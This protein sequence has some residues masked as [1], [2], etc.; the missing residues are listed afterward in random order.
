MVAGTNEG[1]GNDTEYID[2][3]DEESVEEGSDGELRVR[4]SNNASFKKKPGCPTFELGMKFSC[5]NGYIS[6]CYSVTEFKKTYSHCLEPLEGMNNWPYDDRQPLNA[7]GYIKMLGRPRTERRREPTEAPKV[8]RMSK[9]GTKIS[10]RQC[11]QFGHN[12]STCHK[13]SSGGPSTAASHPAGSPA[14]TNAVSLA[15]GLVLSNCTH[16][17]KRKSITSTSTS[18]AIHSVIP[19]PSK[20]KMVKVT[21]TTKVSTNE[22]GSATVYLH[23]IVPYSQASSSA[24]VRLNSGKAVVNVLAQEPVKMKPKKAT[25]GPLLLLPPWESAKL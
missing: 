21:A 10:C 14:G 17:R 2:S 4:G 19:A 18:S 1:D 9:M 15:G 24:S 3:D 20:R 13:H 5:K 6:D 25:P 23:V 8:T 7:P 12:K 11:K 22:G 16:G